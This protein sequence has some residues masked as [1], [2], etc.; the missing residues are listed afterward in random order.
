K[1]DL[2]WD[3]L[4]GKYL[5]EQPVAALEVNPGEGV[6]GEACDEQGEHRGRDGDGQGVDERPSQVERT[7]ARLENLGVVVE[8]ETPVLEDRPPPGRVDQRG[9]PERRDEQ[10]EGGDGP[11]NGDE[12]R[13]EGRPPAGESTLRVLRH[14]PRSAFELLL[15][16]LVD[17][18]LDWS[19]G[20][21]R[22]SFCFFNC[23]AL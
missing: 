1:S 23:L 20:A 2:E 10:T 4:H 18:K 3:D 12:Q 19:G 21:H 7:I 14:R 13:C 17:R 5:D 22:I 9:R 8:R 6:C 16:R 11:E 15:G